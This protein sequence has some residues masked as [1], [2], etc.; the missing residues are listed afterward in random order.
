[1][2][3]S[4]TIMAKFRSLAICTW[5]SL[6]RQSCSQDRSISSFRPDTGSLP[7]CVSPVD[8]V[9][10]SA[11]G[12]VVPVS[13]GETGVWLASGD[14][15][16]RGAGSSS[17]VVATQPIA[18]PIKTISKAVTKTQYPLRLLILLPSSRSI[19]LQAGNVKNGSLEC[20]YLS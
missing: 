18:E 16:G 5:Y 10:A 12:V 19:D 8:V 7:T 6:D 1:M 14:G 4:T 9:S 3:V 2:P 20:V 15:A 17:G 13:G 11:D